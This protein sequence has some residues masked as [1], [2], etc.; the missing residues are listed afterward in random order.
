MVVLVDDVEDD[1][2]VAIGCG[3]VVFFLVA[4]LV[5]S[6]VVSVELV[7]DLQVVEGRPCRY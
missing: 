2:V 1:V 5:E 4:K 6:S 7:V 3:L